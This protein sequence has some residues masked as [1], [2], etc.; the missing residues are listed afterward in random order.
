[1]PRLPTAVLS[2]G[3][4]LLAF[5]SLTCGLILETVTRGRREIKR[6]QYLRVPAPGARA[7]ARDTLNTDS[8]NTD[9]RNKPARDK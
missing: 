3:L 9:S 4:M 1:V 2:T 6:M 8:W 7:P 5:L